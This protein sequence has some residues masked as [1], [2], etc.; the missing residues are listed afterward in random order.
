M[1]LRHPRASPTTPQRPR[2]EH[3]CCRRRTGADGRDRKCVRLSESPREVGATIASAAPAGCTIL[4]TRAPR[5][6]PRQRGLD[7]GSDRR[8]GQERRPRHRQRRQARGG[9]HRRSAARGSRTRRNRAVGRPPG[10]R[11]IAAHPPPA[12]QSRI[13]LIRPAPIPPVAP[14]IRT[15]TLDSAPVAIGDAVVATTASH[16]SDQPRPTESSSSPA[17]S[18]ASR[19]RRAT[20]STRADLSATNLTSP[21]TSSDAPRT[22]H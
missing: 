17:A 3:R 18:N 7:P 20:S 14:P 22:C 10:H 9:V 11:A 5:D 6:P 19:R 21:A 1:S 16:L 13:G 15:T 2:H 8:V 12:I 4:W